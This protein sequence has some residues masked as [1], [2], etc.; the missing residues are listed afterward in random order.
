MEA[1][2]EAPIDELPDCLGDTPLAGAGP[3]LDS[4]LLL[5]E[6]EE[7]AVGPD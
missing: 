5:E 6:E 1:V 3:V 2:Y 4:G 7:V